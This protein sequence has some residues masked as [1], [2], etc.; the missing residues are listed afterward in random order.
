MNKPSLLAATLC[1]LGVALAT[2][3][4][5]QVAVLERQELRAQLT[6]QRY[7]TLA[8]EIGA[9]VSRIAVE[10]GGRFKAGE[11]VLSFDCAVQQAALEKAQA[12]LNASERSLKANIELEK[13][14]SV[15]K[16]EIDL[17]RAAVERNSAEVR[18]NR[19]VLGKCTVRAPFNGRVA[20][21]LVREQQYVQPG[22]P[23]LDILDD[24][25]L[26]LDFIVPSRWLT[27]LKI[28]GAFSVAIDE[29]G[30]TY[31]ARFK[32]I[33]ARVDPVS[34][35]VKVSGVIDGKFPELIAGMSGRVDVTPPA[36]Q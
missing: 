5:A 15:G 10:E 6:A 23:L 32:R 19:A 2:P 14:N 25:T 22:E 21:Q 29:T 26:E 36:N 30:K 20:E 1:A 31:P 33:G 27:W 34:Q 24:S 7:T 17:A 3:A 35:S 13:L 16:L 9:K 8:A 4:A 18:M 12:E 28:G 11:V